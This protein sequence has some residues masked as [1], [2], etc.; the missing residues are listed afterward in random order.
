MCPGDSVRSVRRIPHLRAAPGSCD[1]AALRIPRDSMTS[2]R[3]LR[4]N[5]RWFLGRTTQAAVGLAALTGAKSA[6][7]ADKPNP[8]AYDV[9][10]YETTDPKLIAYRQ[11]TAFKCPTPDARRLCL[12]G[13]DRFAVAAGNEVILLGRSSG[14]L[15]AEIPL[16]G[17]P[18]CV[19]E[20]PDGSLFVGLRDH[21]EVFDAQ[22]NRRA[23]WPTFA[24]RP[25]ISSV[26][27]NGEFV[28]IADSGNRVVY[29]CDLNG[30]A[31][32]R[33]GNRDKDRSIPGFVLPSPFLEVEI[34][35]DGLLRVTNPGRHLIEA[36]TFEGDRATAWGKASMGI[37]GFCGC[38]N[39]VALAILQDGRF[40]T[41]EKGLPRV[42]VYSQEGDFEC[43]VAG[44]ESFP[45]N[46]KVGSG[47]TPGD[48]VKASLDAVV[49]HEGRVFILDTVT[50]MIRVMVRNQAG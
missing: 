22:G 6:R 50:G 18:R 31:I 42:K 13:K 48:G 34:H 24:G 8:F 27:V 40:V 47:E 36:Y 37:Q 32:N 4:R 15:A 3:Q 41:C 16:S 28:F 1:P 17:P 5:R 30:K 25:W 26:A 20:G 33:I 39:P 2:S 43:V 12:V 21:V 19:T 23:T 46:A 35:R 14:A 29:R 9:R 7:A 45:E 11:T 44:V 38:C 49:D 10:K